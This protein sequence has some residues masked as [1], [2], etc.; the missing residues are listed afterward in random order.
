[1]K[2]SNGT[3][4]I[5]PH[6]SSQARGFSHGGGF[7]WIEFGHLHL[8]S[9]ACEH[10]HNSSILLSA[11]FHPSLNIRLKIIVTTQ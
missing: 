5:V 10:K 6:S 4:E 7:R 8:S 1:L 2:L 9:S 11:Q 3:S